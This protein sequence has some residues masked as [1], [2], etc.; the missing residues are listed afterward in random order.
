MARLPRSLAAGVLSA[1]VYAS[2]KGVD[3][4]TGACSTARCQH[5]SS[6]CSRVLQ[7]SAKNIVV[8]SHTAR[9]ALRR[10]PGILRGGTDRQR[11]KS[12]HACAVPSGDDN[13]QCPWWTDGG[14]YG[15]RFRSCAPFILLR[16]STLYAW[17]GLPCNAAQRRVGLYL[18]LALI[19]IGS[20]LVACTRAGPESA[21]GGAAVWWVQIAS[22]AMTGWAL[23]RPQGPTGLVRWGGAGSRG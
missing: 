8:Q 12:I 22:L 9:I 4:Q 18:S 3:L 7:E 6:L 10:A 1:W 23:P 16:G 15:A 5:N 14:S 20:L 13:R 19:L 17:R 11:G 21:R 2:T